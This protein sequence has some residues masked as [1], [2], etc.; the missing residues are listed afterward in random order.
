MPARRRRLRFSAT[1]GAGE[2][3][4][5][6]SAR[7]MLA[8]GPATATPSHPGRA[9]SVR[10][11]RRSRR[12]A[13][14]GRPLS[15]EVNRSMRHLQQ[16]MPGSGL[17]SSK[18]GFVPAAPFSP[19]LDEALLSACGASVRPDGNF[20]TMESPI[21]DAAW[22]SALVHKR[23]AKLGTVRSWLTRLPP[24]MNSEPNQMC[25]L[26]RTFARKRLLELG[27]DSFA[28][29]HACRLRAIF[30]QIRRGVDGSNTQTM[31]A[32]PRMF[33]ESERCS[34]EAGSSERR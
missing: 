14:R 3:W 26:C 32:E 29:A 16:F 23:V 1:S 7:G 2:P 12:P 4:A 6:R 28:I 21:G 17:R 15:A 24:M 10:G 33:E 27:P 8:A 25:E 30:V 20:E 18:V 22:A 9:R 19:T 34:R 31:A 13:S 5:L 11:R